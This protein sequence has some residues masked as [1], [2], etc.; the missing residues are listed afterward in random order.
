MKNSPYR[1]RVVDLVNGLLLYCNTNYAQAS[2][3]MSKVD[4][5]LSRQALW[6]M[7]NNGSLK[8][9]TFLELLDAYGVELKF[10]KEGQEVSYR[11]GIGERVKRVI[12]KKTYDTGKCI[13][14]SSSFYADGENKYT[15]HLADEMYVDPSDDTILLVHYCDSEFAGTAAGKKYPWM[16]IVDS[17]TRAHFVQE[18]GTL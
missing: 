2:A 9:A 11:K 3:K 13:A 12:K 16:E 15:N 1:D 5:P 10:E 7:V 18:Y 8:L 17:D 14:L 4:K 6:K